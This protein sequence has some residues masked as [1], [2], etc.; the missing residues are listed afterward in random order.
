MKAHVALAASALVACGSS[1]SSGARSMDPRDERDLSSMR[2]NSPHAAELYERAEDLFARGEL[3]KADDLFRQSHDEYPDAALP[4]RRDC[5]ARTALGERREAVVA[6]SEAIERGRSDLTIRALVSAFVDGPIPPTS[7]DLYQAWLVT[8][9]ARENPLGQV[10]AAA[11]TCDIAA[12]IGDSA[13]LQRCGGEL[14]RIAPNDPATRKAEAAL[15]AQCPPWR[16][17]G[18]WGALLTLVVFTLVDA[19]RRALARLRRRASLATSTATLL[20]MALVFWVPIVRAEEGPAPGISKWP[21]DLEHPEKG[22][23]SEKERNADPLQFGYWLQDVVAKAEHASKSGD[24][25]T[26][27]RLYGALAAAVPDRAIGFVKLCEELEALGDLA[28]AS[29][30]CGDALLRD[31]V[32]VMDYSHFVRL[33]LTK[34]GPLAEKDTK[35]LAAVL[36]HMKDDPAGRDAVPDLECQVGARTSDVS[37]LEECTA[38]LSARA[39]NDPKTLSYEWALAV[40]EGRFEDARKLGERARVSGVPAENVAAMDRATASTQAHRRWEMIFSVAGVAL[41]IALAG[42]LGRSLLRRT[43]GVDSDVAVPLSLR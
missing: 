8:A 39:P 43:R 7:S 35:A 15:S 9:R 24:H 5:E 13:M 28:K 38:I 26:A 6:C 31:G 14:V 19:L 11:A 4:W 16:F 1:S 17:W 23:P 34:P 33:M 30:A 32:R 40:A 10:T 22:I 2:A 27:S 25:L 37:Q 36:K 42:L 29:S 41:F 18:G 21:V 3:A 12:R 20:S